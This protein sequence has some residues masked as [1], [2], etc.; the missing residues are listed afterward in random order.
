[1]NELFIGHTKQ[2]IILRRGLRQPTFPSVAVI[3]YIAFSH[4]LNSIDIKKIFSP[5]LHLR[6]YIIMY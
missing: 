3:T 6:Q 5:C 1:M 2:R 4:G